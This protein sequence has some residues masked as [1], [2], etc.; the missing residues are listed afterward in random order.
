MS[1]AKLSVSNEENA[2]V[3]ELSKYGSMNAESIMISLERL[4]KLLRATS[5]MHYRIIL[6]LLY[7]AFSA[8]EASFRL[9]FM[10]AFME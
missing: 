8:T 4:N 7:N 5:N 10:V 1:L 9:V 6:G 2:Y 3:C